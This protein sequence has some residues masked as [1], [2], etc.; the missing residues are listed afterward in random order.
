M[1]YPGKMPAMIIDTDVGYDDLLAILYLLAE[2]SIDIE[3]FTV[4]NG[5]STVP[6]GANALLWV[7]EQLGLANPIPVYRGESKQ[8]NSFPDDWRN[9]ACKLGWTHPVKLKPQ[10]QPAVEFL[11]QRLSKSEPAQ[12]LMIGPQTNIA[13]AL[14]GMPL[15]APFTATVMGGA[16][17][18]PGN[19]P[20]SDPVAEANIYV[21]PPAA[22]TFF[23]YISNS[24]SSV[25]VVPLD[26]CNRVPVT[27]EFIQTFSRLSVPTSK[28]GYWKLAKSPHPDI[29]RVRVPAASR[30]RL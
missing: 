22:S 17:Y 12:L 15:I 16:F 30:L 21:D 18:V 8:P 20:Q 5:I 28:A 13:G 24:L 26:A 1:D 25:S 3:A 6:D 2:G 9:Q 11:K 19:L 4:V 27:A 14:T 23:N 29:E 10:P 7:Q